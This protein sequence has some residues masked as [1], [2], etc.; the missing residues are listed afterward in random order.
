MKLD[1]Q[2]ASVIPGELL[3]K[4]SVLIYILVFHNVQNRGIFLREAVTHTL[5]GWQRQ[6]ILLHLFKLSLPIKWEDQ[7]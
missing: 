4:K 6:S 7:C 5:W 3:K 2:P 1:M